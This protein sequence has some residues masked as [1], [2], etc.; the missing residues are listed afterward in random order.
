MAGAL[1]TT[2]VLGGL[3]LERLTA[4][5]RGGHV[6]KEL[7]DPVG[8]GI[9][10]GTVSDNSNVGLGVDD[11]S[12]ARDV[13]LVQVLVDRRSRGRIH[14]STE[15]TVEGNGVSVVEGEGRDVSVEGGLLQVQNSLDILMELVGY[16]SISLKAIPSSI[17]GNWVL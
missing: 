16:T 8:Q 7:A 9:S 2:V 11:V 10:G 6:L 15:T 17:N 14:R 13:L 1:L 3:C 4:L 5:G 12:V